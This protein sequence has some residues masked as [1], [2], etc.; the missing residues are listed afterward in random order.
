MTG[1][2]TCGNKEAADIVTCKESSE[3]LEGN[4]RLICAAI[5]FLHIIFLFGSSLLGL[6]A[7]FREHFLV[8][9]DISLCY[10][11][12]EHLIGQFCKDQNCVLTSTAS[13]FNIVSSY[14][15]YARQL[16]ND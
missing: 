2:P 10:H 12:T 14:I 5:H 4:Q 3:Y 6:Q 11:L 8:R 7:S 9:V 1:T 16:M 13:V 15:I